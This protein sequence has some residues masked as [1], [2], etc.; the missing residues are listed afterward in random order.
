MV[1]NK[2]VILYREKRDKNALKTL[3]QKQQKQRH[4]YKTNGAILYTERRDRVAFS[5]LI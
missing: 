3:A 4:K 5:A 1:L 2:R